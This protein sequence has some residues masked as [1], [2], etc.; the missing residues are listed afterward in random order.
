M[1]NFT[2]NKKRIHNTIEDRLNELTIFSLD[3]SA[4][5]SSLKSYGLRLQEISL[6]FDRV[7]PHLNAQE[8]AKFEKLKE[9][10]SNFE[11]VYQSAQES[12]DKRKYQAPR[13]GF[14][15]RIRSIADLRPHVD[16]PRRARS[17]IPFHRST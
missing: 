17:A 3:L 7:S 16:E 5:P 10:F 14:I 9:R 2:P 6:L 8:S 1:I 4:D 13:R 11:R 12:P 15:A